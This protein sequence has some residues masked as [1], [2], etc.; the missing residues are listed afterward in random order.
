MMIKETDAHQRKKEGIAEEYGIPASISA[1]IIKDEKEISERSPSGDYSRKRK[2]DPDVDEAILK[3]S[4]QCRDQKISIPGPMI[5]RE[6]FDYARRIGHDYFQGGTGWMQGIKTKNR[7]IPRR[8]SGGSA[9]VNST[10]FVKTMPD[11][12]FVLK[13]GSCL[14]D[15]FSV[16]RVTVLFGCKC[17]WN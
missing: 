6:A 9:A 4:K 12:L 2:R 15:E 8:I 5:C 16:E 7:I 11:K 1:T 14:G 3:W 10:L 17:S 13:N